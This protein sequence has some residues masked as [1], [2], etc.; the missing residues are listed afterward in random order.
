MS[1]LPPLSARAIRLGLPL[2]HTYTPPPGPFYDPELYPDCTI[3]LS[4]AENSLLSP[5]LIEVFL[6][7]LAECVFIQHYLQHLSRPITFH[8]QHLK[9]RYTL[10]KSTLPTVEDLLPEY[11]NSHF[12][13]RIQ[14][15]RK[16]SV[17]GPGIGALLAQ[18]IWALTDED[19][20]VLLSDPFYDEYA[21]DIVHPARAVVVLPGIPRESDSL[22]LEVLPYL[23]KKLLE[24]DMKIKV[25]ILC[26]PH[27]PIPQVIS[28]EV[29]E[30]YARLA[31]KYNLHLV[32]DEVYGLSTFTA[33]RYPPANP[34]KFESILSYDLP[35]LSVDPSRVHVLAGPTKDFGASG[36]KLGLLISP[37]NL[38]LLKL[39]RPLFNATP[40]SSLSDALFVRVLSD[41]P[42]VR[43]F[44]ADNRRAL[45]Q[46]YD[47]VAD[48]MT[49][50]NLSFTR[51]NAGVF[52]LVD[53]APFLVRIAPPSAGTTEQLDCGVAAMLREKVFLKPTNLMADPIP[54][55]FRLIFTQPKDTMKLA[56]RRIEKA[57][58]VEEA[59]FS[60]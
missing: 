35:A 48:W 12:N 5:R 31:Q 34:A 24:T 6:S 42:F 11:I 10:L 16:N 23:E 40:I 46:A 60:D 20:G 37:S 8:K 58:R 28:R 51:A 53:L 1:H 18:L 59:P 25:L 14:I 45:G 50:H 33:T 32:V 9:Y 43:T 17:A 57:F 44:L 47:L 29:V 49:F 7:S 3:N 41:K 55:R 4:T 56:L 38:T 26:N 27:N 52:V 39:V 15:T 21:R 54:T 13:P 36:V 2:P 30:G 19:D 22:S